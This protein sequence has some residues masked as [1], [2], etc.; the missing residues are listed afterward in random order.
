[1]YVCLCKNITC[2]QIR[3]AVQNGDA[4]SMRDLSQKLGVA[5]QCGKC[6]RCARGILQDTL[7]QRSQNDVQIEQ[8]SAA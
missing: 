2:G 1:M 5:T 8:I 3:T 6:G 4:G 7:V